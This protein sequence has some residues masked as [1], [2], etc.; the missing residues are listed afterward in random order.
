MEHHN[1]SGTDGNTAS[2]SQI[3]LIRLFEG[4]ALDVLATIPDQTYT[5]V[6]TDPPYGLS[7]PPDPVDVLTQWL[8]QGDFTRGKGGRK[9]AP[10]PGLSEL[11]ARFAKTAG[12]AG[13]LGHAWDSF[14]PGPRLWR[15]V[16]RVCKPGAIAAVFAATRTQHWMALGLVM[17]GFEVIDTVGWVNA[18]GMSKS[19]TVDKRIDRRRHDRDVVLRCTKWIR[20]RCNAL[21]LKPRDL[22]VACGTHGMGSHWTS[23]KSQPYVPT[24]EQWA[25]LEPLLG[26]MPPEMEA[27]RL[28][29]E[30]RA[31]GE[32]WAK[33]EV[34]GKHPSPASADATRVAMGDGWQATP[35][36]TM[37]AT[38]VSAEWAGYST[39]LA[40]GIEPIIIVRRPCEGTAVQ[41][42]L[43]HSCGAMNIDACRIE[44]GADYH[45]LK[46]TQG[47]NT[48]GV[49]PLSG[50]EGEGEASKFVSHA[51]GKWP[52][53]VM[54]SAE[55][56]AILD[57]QV[58]ERASGARRA[59]ARKGIGYGSNATG[60]GG[61][62]IESS[63][64]GPSRFFWVGP[65][66]TADDVDLPIRYVPKASKADRAAGLPEG[67]K[68]DHPTCKPPALIE[69]LC[70]LVGHPRG[71]LLDPFVGSGTTPRAA[72]K[73]GLPCDGIERDHHYCIDLAA[74]RAGVDPAD[75]RRVDP[76][77]PLETIA[78]MPP[79]PAHPLPE[80]E[81]V[82]TVGPRPLPVTIDAIMPT[83]E[84]PPP[85]RLAVDDFAGVPPIFP[86]LPGAPETT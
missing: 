45:D 76:P 14:V 77:T 46:V 25:K 10:P 6:V 71:R 68:G 13:F 54:L 3:P 33:R 29:I 44:A 69:W 60:D 16:F 80:L 70:R 4:D 1:Q 72:R 42:V 58:G 59:G 66:A 37:P 49:V 24:R 34:I 20:E 47:R 64:G 57:D 19:G 17:A 11:A 51:L 27:Q 43:A 36:L 41:N 85:Q 83:L 23:T 18:Q 12:P 7:Q 75:V 67:T 74:P 82:T 73:L 61:P 62:A 30:A 84:I 56:A 15:E 81:L 8:L 55:A 21:K 79:A 31:P 78:D 32:D 50:A 2:S 40:P 52:K 5:A 22:D 53:N 35:D 28:I 48:G 9:K 65:L 63:R 39:Q 38:D 26:P 86:R